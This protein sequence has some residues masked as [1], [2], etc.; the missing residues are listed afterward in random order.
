MHR[1]AA[2][3]AFYPVT[4]PSPLLGLGVPWPTG[5]VIGYLA[6]AGLCGGGGS[7]GPTTSSPWEVLAT[8]ALTRLVGSF[9]VPPV[10]P[11]SQLGRHVC[12][13]KVAKS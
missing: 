11:T 6:G 9:E 10:R 12:I 7:D 5:R 8:L 2:S 4:D 13:K 1:L 3:V